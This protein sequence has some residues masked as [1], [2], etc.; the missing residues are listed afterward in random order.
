MTPHGQLV[1]RH[2]LPYRTRK[3]THESNEML[4]P[5]QTYAQNISISKKPETHMLIQK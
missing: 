3:T 5:L 1:S 2:T 4:L